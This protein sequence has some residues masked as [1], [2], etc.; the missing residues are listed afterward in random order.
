MTTANAPAHNPHLDPRLI[1][2]TDQGSPRISLEK[3]KETGMEEDQQQNRP[4]LQGT[5]E[6]GTPGAAPGTH[7]AQ[8]S[9]NEISKLKIFNEQILHTY[10]KN[11]VQ[12]ILNI[13]K[14]YKV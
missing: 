2:F 10:S 8:D 12:K 3:E 9:V 13:N 1:I 4:A 14:V 7:Q 11:Y 6:G 5:G